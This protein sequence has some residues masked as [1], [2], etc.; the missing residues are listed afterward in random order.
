MT[1][2][3]GP[4]QRHT[5]AAFLVAA[6]HAG[7]AR[8]ALQDEIQVYLDEL[9]ARGEWGLELHVNTTPSGVAT[10]SYPGEVVSAHGTRVTPELSYGLGHALEA[11]LYVPTVIDAEGHGAVAGAK[12]R[13]KWLPVA[14]GESSAG[15]FAGANGELSRVAAAYEEA[16]CAAELRL[17]GGRRI[18]GWTLAVNPVFDWPLSGGTG[19]A[20]ADFNVGVKAAREVAAG[21]ALGA[22]YYADAGPWNHPL[23]SS[24]Q[25]RRLYLAADIDRRPWVLNVGVGYGLTPASDR[26]TV[27]LIIEIP[28]RSAS[29][30]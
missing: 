9:D 4:R 21:V 5:L 1:R 11:G 19:R 14:G 20:T 29:S 15:W 30:D 2:A 3:P 25:D 10:P 12:L 28:L 22:E 17:I 8:A 18:R 27:K 23:P 24:R 16:R 7:G 26:W 6:L 13:L